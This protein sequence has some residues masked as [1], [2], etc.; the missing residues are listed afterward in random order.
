MG[1]IADSAFPVSKK[2]YK[3]II[4]P[5]KDGELDR[6]PIQA[7]AGAMALSNAIVSTRQAAEWGMGAIAKCFRRL[8]QPLPFNPVIRAQRLGNI[9]RLYNFRVRKTNISQIRNV[10]FS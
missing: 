9:Y 4:T 3:K 7:R 6:Y 5:L 2:L 1:A 10:F 8:Q